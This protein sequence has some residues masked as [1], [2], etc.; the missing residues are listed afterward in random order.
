MHLLVSILKGN[1]VSSRKNGDLGK[2]E[3]FMLDIST[4]KVDFAVVSFGGIL[5]TGDS[6]FAVPMRVLEL[7]TEAGQFLLDLG[8]DTQ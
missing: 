2:V 3:D 8:K 5:G 6:L 4:S 1:R 7:D